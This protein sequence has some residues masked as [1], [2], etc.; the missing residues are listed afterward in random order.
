MLEMPEPVKDAVRDK[1]VPVAATTALK[2]LRESGPEKAAEN[3]KAGQ[4]VARA[5]GRNRTL[6]RDIAKA[7]GTP[8]AKKT[9]NEHLTDFAAV[10]NSMRDAAQL[11]GGVENITPAMKDALARDMLGALDKLMGRNG[12]AGAESNPLPP[13]T[14]EQ[15]R[16]YLKPPEGA[17]LTPSAT[18]AADQPAPP[19]PLSDVPPASV[20]PI[21]T[22]RGADF[23]P[24]GEWPLE[25]AELQADDSSPS[26]WIG[27]HNTHDRER[28]V[29]LLRVVTGVES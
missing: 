29:E 15:Q 6:P 9:N 16:E 10:A 28:V 11:A 5:A 13:R 3:L 26:L 4:A 1:E 7:K 17:T 24:N 8:H 23:Q 19:P 2:E 22:E 18:D 14:A 25:V 20:E 12:N 21:T 27:F